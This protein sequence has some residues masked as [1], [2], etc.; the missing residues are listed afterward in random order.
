MGPT[1]VSRP[2]ILVVRG[3]GQ[4]HFFFHLEDSGRLNERWDDK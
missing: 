1:G 3:S 4:K 2:G